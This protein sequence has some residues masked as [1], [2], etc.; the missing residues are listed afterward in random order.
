MG[1]EEI[2]LPFLSVLSS[3]APTNQ[4]REGCLDVEEEKGA[5]AGEVEEEAVNLNAKTLTPA[6]VVTVKEA[7]EK[8]K[9]K[10]LNAKTR[11]PA[12]VEIVKEAGAKDPTD[13]I[14]R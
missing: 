14:K 2:P 3:L 11:T 10:N 12:A 9:V 13:L 7:G 1:T 5:G 6:A 4:A 8:V